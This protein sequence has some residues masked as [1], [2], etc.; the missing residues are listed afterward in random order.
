MP[1]TD[2]PNS[3]G[4]V[5][6]IVSV[7]AVPRGPTAFSVTLYSLAGFR[8]P[9]EVQEV[10]LSNVRVGGECPVVVSSSVIWYSVAS[11]CICHVN[12]ADMSE[13][14][15]ITLLLDSVGGLGGLTSLSRTSAVPTRA[16]PGTV[17]DLP[18]LPLLLRAR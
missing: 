2:S 9:T 14:S 16:V 8:P 1:D 3:G 15:T 11:G 4:G 13:P 17:I 12:L 5:Q 6:I 18:T 7:S 10:N